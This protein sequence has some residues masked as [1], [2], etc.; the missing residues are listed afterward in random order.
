MFSVARKS[1]L[2]TGGSKGI[3]LGIA[4]VF[5][6]ADAHVAIAARSRSDLA[7]TPEF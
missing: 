7:L 1:V 5:A 4:S 6:A 3:G 2:V